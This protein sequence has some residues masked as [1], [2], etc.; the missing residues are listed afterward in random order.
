MSKKQKYLIIHCTASRPE[1]KVDKGYFE[2]LHKGPCDNADGT[3]TYLGKKYKNRSLLP[4]ETQGGVSIKTLKGRGWRRFGYRGAVIQDGS[5]LELSPNNGDSIIEDWEITNGATGINDVAEHIVYAG[6]VD[7]NDPKKAKDT[8]TQPQKAK[9]AALCFEEIKQ[10]PSVLIGG[11]YHFAQKAC[12]S[13]NVEV[14]L[15][16]IGIPEKNIY[17]KGK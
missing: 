8:R 12:P 11:H 14:W 7:A 16:S 17:R 13:F 9:L 10:N 5:W 6:G 3:V 1:T 2:R 4:N 15:Q